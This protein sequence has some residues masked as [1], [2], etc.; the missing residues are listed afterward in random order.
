MTRRD[1]ASRPDI[2]YIISAY[3]RPWMLPVCVWSLLGQSHRNFEVIV[4]DNATDKWTIAA[5][6]KAIADA[7]AYDPSRAERFIYVHTG[8]KIKVSD[9]YWSAEWAVKNIARGQWL[10]FPC[11]DTYL[12]PEYGARMLTRAYEKS[13]D[14]VICGDVVL[15]PEGNGRVG[16]KHWK[17]VPGRASKTTFMVRA[18]KFPGFNGKLQYEGATMADWQLTRDIERVGSVGTVEDQLMVV[19]N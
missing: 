13:L 3:N 11:D 14:M 10:C 16:Y 15:G 17:M 4:T 7:K 6:Q 9:C 8:K 12:A 5:H 2:S 19:H 1:S 18:D